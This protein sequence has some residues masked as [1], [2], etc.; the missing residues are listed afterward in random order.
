MPPLVHEGIGTMSG[1]AS[2]VG[3]HEV[4]EGKTRMSDGVA[5]SG[6]TGSRRTTSPW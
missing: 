3:D 6:M 2:V 4:A 5:S 1:F